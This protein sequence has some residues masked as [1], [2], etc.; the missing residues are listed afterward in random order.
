MQQLEQVA[1]TRFFCY[2]IGAFIFLTSRP[3][4][5]SVAMVGAVDF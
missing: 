1:K 4:R 2:L 5:L 3:Q